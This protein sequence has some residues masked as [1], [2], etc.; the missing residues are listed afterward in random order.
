[1]KEKV[2]NWIQQFNTFCFL[3]NHQY[4]IQPHTQECLVA[5]GEKRNFKFSATTS[6]TQ[7][8]HFIDAR[9]N[10]WLFGHINYDLKNM[11]E[12]LSSTRIR[13]DFRSC[14]FLNPLLL[15]G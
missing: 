13:L 5:A 11:L 3:D 7:W 8:Q 14:F 4:Q 12:H 9:N 15:S 1:M 10:G 2:L 6:L